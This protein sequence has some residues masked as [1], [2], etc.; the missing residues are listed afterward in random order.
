MGFEIPVYVNGD[1][2]CHTV[3]KV[4]ELGEKVDVLPILD[5]LNQ[6]VID[7]EHA[8]ISKEIGTQHF[9]TVPFSIGENIKVEYV[10]YD[11]TIQIEINLK[12]LRIREVSFEKDSI[13]TIPQALVYPE[14]FSS[15]INFNFTK[16]FTHYYFTHYSASSSI[17]GSTNFCFNFKDW[18]LEG[19]A[20]LL[21]YGKGAKNNATYKVNRGNIFLTKDFFDKD[22]RFILGDISPSV[23]GFQNSVPLFGLQMLRNP[24][25]FGKKDPNIGP[26]G[27]HEIFLNA[28]S[29]V[30][31]YINEVLIRTIDLPAGPHLLT[32]FPYADGLNKV[33]LVISDPMGN[34]K[35][36]NLTAVY[37]YQLLKP[38]DYYY[39]ASLGFPRFQQASQQYKYA[40]NTPAFSACFARGISTSLTLK[41]YVQATF[42][43]FF[44]GV[45]F[46]SANSIFLLKS[47]TG[48]SYFSSNLGG[49]KQSISFRN[50]KNTTPF[51]WQFG[52][53][54][55]SR[56]FSYFLSK[57][58][59]NPT[60]YNFNGS[61]EFFLG[62][63]ISTTF[64]GF[65][66]VSRVHFPNTYGISWNLGGTPKKGVS[67]GILTSYQKLTNG[68]KVFNSIFSLN[69]SIGAGKTL[70]ARYNSR[71][72]E[73]NA[74]GSYYKKLS[75]QRSINTTMGYAQLAGRKNF[76]GSLN[77]QGD[78]GSLQFNQYLAENALVPV[79]PKSNV[80]SVTRITGRTS[81]V[82]AGKTLAISR[83]VSGSF[84]IIQPKPFLKNYSFEACLRS[85][86]NPVS[87]SSKFLPAVVTDI[88]SYTYTKVL[89]EPEDVLI[90][91]D[92]G[93]TE[94]TLYSKYKSGFKL[95]IGGKGRRHYAE[96]F[97]KNQDE[98]PIKYKTLTIT[99]KDGIEQ[100][101]N[102]FTNSQGKFCLLEINIGV[103]FVKIDGI[104]HSPI[105]III[106]DQY[107]KELLELGSLKV[108]IYSQYEK[109]ESINSQSNN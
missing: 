72:N 94:Y 22:K 102:S 84:A 10:P 89:V 54:F 81:L 19:F 7:E 57:L 56:N 59:D 65:Y 52:F 69:T 43:S 29:K 109:I 87:R 26:V 2:Q 6:L 88:G 103:Y 14:S 18:I 36:L 92:L 62:K 20:Y 17:Y 33:D 44:S 21:T 86:G 8:L 15:Y 46:L 23:V 4:D 78:R 24:Q 101:M 66:G 47:E 79:A 93:E 49:I 53:D 64:Q 61:L 40:F 71:T 95:N 99:D 91:Y 97:L 48:L 51:S 11:Q 27:Q 16:N 83:P 67:L 96:G 82:Y 25:I 100:E 68:Q 42:D 85:F 77:Y 1:F 37:S 63:R 12:I 76:T 58:R 38:R 32:N 5:A 73:I 13:K 70:G 55:C 108:E 3:F 75:R 107:E 98:Q 106:S 28:P 41:G 90:G 30:D 60:A 45:S 50:T 34:V 39:S 104:E 74:T 35:T 9:K 80:S 105:E 31:V